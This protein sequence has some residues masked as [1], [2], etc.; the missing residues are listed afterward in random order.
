MCSLPVH[1]K[2]NVG[3]AMGKLAKRQA[4]CEFVRVF[5]SRWYVL[6]EQPSVNLVLR[7]WNMRHLQ[8]GFGLFINIKNARFLLFVWV[9]FSKA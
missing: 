6:G 2:Q 9:L 5:W 3:L 1:K 4:I 7:R 8:S